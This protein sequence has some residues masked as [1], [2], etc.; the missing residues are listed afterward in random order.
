MGFWIYI[1]ECA[2][3]SYYTGHT[4]DLEKRLYEH[5]KNIVKCY[6]SK[7]L[8]I[9]LVYAYE[10]ETRED[11]LERERQIKRWSRRKKQALIAEDWNSLIKYSKS[12]TNRPSTSS[13]RTGKI[14]Y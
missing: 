9:R 12:R 4:D 3:N 11:A 5:E 14:R 7:R 10:F 1:L 13:G 8:P 6:T 2:D